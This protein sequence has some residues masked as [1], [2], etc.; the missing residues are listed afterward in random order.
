VKHLVLRG[1]THP[2]LAPLWGPFRRDAGAIFMLH[3]FADAK[4]GVNGHAHDPAELRRY[5]AFLRRERYRVVSLGEL[6]DVL[7]DGGELTRTVAFTVDDA[8]DD[9]VRVG[10]PIF[11]EFD[12]PVTLFVTTGFVDGAWWFWWD[13]VEHALRTTSRREVVLEIGETNAAYRWTTDV[14]RAGV[15]AVLIE[16]LKL[17]ADVEKEAVIATLVERLEVELPAKAPE[18]CTAMTWDDVRACVARGTTVGPHTLSH[19]ILSRVSDDRAA[20]EI[21]ESWSR[22]RGQVRD[23]LP[24][25]CYP[26]G[27]PESFTDRERALVRALGLRSAV[28][29][30]QDYARV[31]HLAMPEA[32]S[33]DGTGR[34]ALPRFAYPMSQAHLTQ[35]VSGLERAKQTARRLIPL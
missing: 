32:S 34:F 21:R 22:L 24:V 25:F 6:L 14:E 11:A 8:Y 1:L 20:I 28:C 7:E 31:R 27:N 35:V 10:H 15:T 4:P 3:R 19:P 16:R 23:P 13:Q 29:A 33:P 26:N 17:V 9:F 5:L 30:I 2:A 18:W 12:V